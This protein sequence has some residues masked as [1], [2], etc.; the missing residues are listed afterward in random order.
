MEV[1]DKKH[2]EIC[3]VQ[4]KILLDILDFSDVRNNVI[5]ILGALARAVD[6]GMLDGSCIST[7]RV[8]TISC[9]FQELLAEAPHHFAYGNEDVRLRL[10]AA[11]PQLPEKP[12]SE[13]VNMGY[14]SDFC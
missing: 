4:E 12:T 1:Y 9:P 2:F 7:V 14:S 6:A 5:V 3:V 11:F 10:R 13:S 8:N